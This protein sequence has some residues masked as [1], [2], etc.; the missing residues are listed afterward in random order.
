MRAVSNRFARK[1][2]DNSNMLVKASVVF[3]DGTR[4]ELTGDD[5]CA[6]SVESACSSAGSFDIG[7]AIIGKLECTLNNYDDRFSEYDFQDA[8]LA[9][10][11]GEQ[12]DNGETEWIRLGVYWCDQPD[13]YAGQIQISA[14]DC[15]HKLE[16]KVDWSVF[17][18]PNTLPYFAEKACEQCGLVFE[19]SEDMRSGFSI[20]KKPSNPDMSWLDLLGY[21]AQI[22]C[23]FIVATDDGHVALKWYDT[24]AFEREEWLDG[25]HFDSDDPYS[26]GGSAD[27]GSFAD[28]SA[29]ANVEG[30]TFLGSNGRVLVSKFSQLTVCTD[31]VVITGV[32]VTEQNE[33]KDV[34]DVEVNGEDG[35]TSLFGSNGYVLSIAKNPFILYSLGKD[36][37]SSVGKRCVGM[38]FRP[39]SAD[40]VADP[41]IEVGDPVVII[42]RKDNVYR[43]YVTGL[44][45]NVNG[46]MS[47]SC[48]AKSPGRNA[49]EQASAATK[50]IVAARND[51]KREQT[52]RELAYRDLQDK[53]AESGGLFTTRQTLA[54]GS[55]VTFMHNRADLASS[56]IIWKMTAEA[57]AVSTDGGK[58]YATGLSADGTAL[59]NRIYAIGLD[60][61]YINTGTLDASKVSIAN[62]MGIGSSEA[63]ILI[64][65]RQ[66]GFFS[67][68]NLMLGISSIPYS[69]KTFCTFAYDGVLFENTSSTTAAK[70]VSFSLGVP[71]EKVF[72]K[73]SSGKYANRFG[74]TIKWRRKPAKYYETFK[75]NIDES[76]F[77]QIP[78]RTMS[79]NTPYGEFSIG[80]T[81]GEDGNA[82]LTIAP[83][84]GKP[85]AGEIKAIDFFYSVDSPSANI[86]TPG[87][88]V[89][90]AENLTSVLRD[91]YDSYCLSL[92]YAYNNS[93]MNV[94]I[95][96]VGGLVAKVE[97]VTP[98]SDVFNHIPALYP[99]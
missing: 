38:R 98:T 45:L 55:T 3:A 67:G 39:F 97:I 96:I 86:S 94:L 66:I 27:G 8:R 22:S 2:A 49:A 72:Y 93:M 29:G 19:A 65:G 31:D 21:I 77:E 43:S 69:V 75:T 95:Y 36:V 23:G 50:A 41:S 18:Y 14:L 73:N 82:Q 5:F 59:L 79:R 76:E 17:E 85:V 46:S 63:H 92:P 25:G 81:R 24:T 90:T 87:D 15:L 88:K 42:D 70:P 53:V 80:I 35:K 54:D 99:M 1:L 6:V 11:V 84:T 10:S 4:K 32:S 62:M 68:Q 26:S 52:A 51:L 34:S 12:F 30:G 74:F 60:A 64:D 37:S 28:Y 71:Y 61:S 33:V 40:I 78:D 48:E 57:V 44:T 89:L 91:H 9:V 20:H 7:S 13:S 16:G 47:I 58:T 56:K 83:G